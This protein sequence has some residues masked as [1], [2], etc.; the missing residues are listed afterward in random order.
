MA[1]NGRKISRRPCRPAGASR[2]SFGANA[3]GPAQPT[4]P[5]YIRSGARRW[6]SCWEPMCAEGNFWVPKP[7]STPR[8][9]RWWNNGG[10]AGSTR[11]PGRPSTK[12]AVVVLDSRSGGGAGDRGGATTLPQPVNRQQW[13][14]ASRVA[15]SKLF[16]LPGRTAERPGARASAFAGDALTGQVQHSPVPAGATSA[17]AR[18]SRQQQHLRPLAAQQLGSK[19]KQD[20]PKTLGTA[21]AL[22]AVP[23][24]PR[25]ERGCAFDRATA[26]YGAVPMRKSCMPPSNNPPPSRRETCGGLESAR[27]LGGQEA[28]ESGDQPARPVLKPEHPS[29]SGVCCAASC[30]PG[31]RRGASLG[32]RRA[33]DGNTNAGRNLSMWVI[34]PRRH[35]VMDLA[36]QNDQT[37]PPLG[38]QRR[39]ARAMGDIIRASGRGAASAFEQGGRDP[40]ARAFASCCGFGAACW[41]WW[42]SALLAAAV[43]HLALASQRSCC[44]PGCGPAAA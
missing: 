13:L 40:D 10:G 32:G 34:E 11:R 38:L 19:V 24:W 41:R 12:G 36:G 21:R 39:A 2:F 27:C 17:C 16:H 18:P 7:S 30:A 8:C 28:P 14:C 3:C 35:W 6:G 31:H 15:P 33:H 44:P 42:L 23:A 9:S 20:G 43:R 4:A 22:G 26:A 29:S 25:S 5:F 1:D 37:K